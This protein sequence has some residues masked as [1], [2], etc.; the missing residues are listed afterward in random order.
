MLSFPVI[1]DITIIQ[2]YNKNVDISTSER[3]GSI[4]DILKNKRIWQNA[5]LCIAVL[6][7]GWIFLYSQ[8]WGWRS[9]VRRAF[10]AAAGVMFVAACAW[11]VF[12]IGKAGK[13]PDRSQLFILLGQV[14]AC[15]GD[16]VINYEFAAGAALF[17]V[18]HIGFFVSFCFLGGGRLRSF[19]FM[20]C[21]CA[22]SLTAL[23]LIPNLALDDMAP[24][25]YTY[26]VIISC[27]LGKAAA[28]LWENSLSVKHRAL[29]FAG[30]LTFYL[31]DLM[32][33]ICMFASGG[34]LFDIA[35]LM[36]YYP[37]ECLLAISA[38]CVRR[39]KEQ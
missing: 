17:A 29:T 9:D 22:V 34:K 7:L 19:I 3:K 24:V 15:L 10:K 14:F 27:M 5:L 6:A 25:I 33:L 20:V 28:L 30:A 39:M 23:Q 37:A 32:L 16:I 1:V 35:C 21:T 26:A 13:K 18:G 4:M 11:N 8:F 12:V 31:S 38:G 2:L 36:L